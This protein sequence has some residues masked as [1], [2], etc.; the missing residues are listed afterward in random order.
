MTMIR[1]AVMVAVGLAMMSASASANVLKPEEVKLKDGQ[2]AKSL[3]GKPGD[4]AK[5][6][7][8]FVNRKLGNCLACHV[9]SEIKDEQFHGETGPTMDGVASRYD[10]ATL[11]AILIN[12]KE[13]FGDHTLM[14]S[15]YRVTGINRPRPQFEGKPILT[16]QQVEDVLAYIMTL[17]SED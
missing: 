15:F 10:E 1:N 6:R 9:N 16:A 8:W 13:V 12:S 11:R 17:K 3:T 14:P 5:G 4:P 7:Q 2:F